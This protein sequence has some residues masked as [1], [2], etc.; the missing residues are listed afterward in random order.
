MSMTFETD[1]GG[2][3]VY[4]GAAAVQHRL[5]NWCATPRGSF[6][7]RPNYGHTLTQFLHET[8][9]DTLAS[10]IETELVIRLAEDLPEIE[11]QWVRVEPSEEFDA[12]RLKVGY[13]TD[14][15]LG[16]SETTVTRG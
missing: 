2:F 11:L 7:G 3:V 6:F 9:T 4:E 1:A 10:V 8:P 13:Q 5:E 16:V 12:Y 14:E 15:L